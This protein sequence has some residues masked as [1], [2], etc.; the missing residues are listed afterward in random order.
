MSVSLYLESV[1]GTALKE[2]STGLSGMLSK[3]AFLKIL[4]AQMSHPDPF[5]PQDPG[6]F[7]TEMAQ[8]ALLEQLMNLSARMEAV[9]RLEAL[10]QAAGLIGREVTVTDGGENVAG[11]VEKVVLGKEKVMLMINGASYDAASLVEV[12]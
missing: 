8:I 7:V 4:V 5:A 1:G 9:Y 3:D 2:A 12:K 10:N 6:A 11:I